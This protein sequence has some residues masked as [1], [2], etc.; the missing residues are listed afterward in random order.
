MCAEDLRRHFLQQVS[1]QQEKL[2]TSVLRKERVTITPDI[3]SKKK[4]LILNKI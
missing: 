3:E 1:F 2:S 4:K